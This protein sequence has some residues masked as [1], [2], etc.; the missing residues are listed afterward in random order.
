MRSVITYTDIN[1]VIVRDA[2]Y[3]PGD[4]SVRNANTLRETRATLRH[5]EDLNRKYPPHKSVYDR[6]GEAISAGAKNAAE[7]IMD[8]VAPE[9][10]GY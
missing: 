6:A 3:I 5:L 8:M 7:I 4:T 1:G 9:F 2:I 10:K